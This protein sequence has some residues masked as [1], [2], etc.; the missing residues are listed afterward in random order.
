MKHSS[1]FYAIC[2]CYGYYILGIFL[3]GLFV[4]RDNKVALILIVMIPTIL[5]LA[6]IS[7]VVHSVQ[8][9]AKKK[10]PVRRASRV[11]SKPRSV[12]AVR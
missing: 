3:S 4:L 5:F 9:P 10:L 2:A 6:Y 8:P 12:K 11:A 1:R 7:M